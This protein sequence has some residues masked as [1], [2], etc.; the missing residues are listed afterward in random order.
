MPRIFLKPNLWQAVLPAVLAV[1]ALAV[2]APGCGVDDVDRT[3]PDKVRKCLFFE[4]GCEA[5]PSIIGRSP[6]EFYFNQTVIEVPAT[7]ELTFVGET[8]F[9]T[10]N[11]VFFEIQEDHLYVYRS[12]P[13]LEATDP[14]AINRG[15]DLTRTSGP[16]GAPIAVFPIE[17]H[18]DVIREYNAATGE[19]TNV[20]VEN[21]VDRPWY[22]RDFMRVDWTTNLVGDTN[23]PVSTVEGQVSYVVPQEDG[24]RDLG[25]ERTVLTPDYIDFVQY[26]ALEPDIIPGSEEFFGFPI[27]TCWLFTRLHQ[28]CQGG[29]I[30]IRN[31]FAKVPA[32][33][34][35]SV[36][37][38]DR[39]LADY[40]AFRTERYQYD[41]E[42]GVVEPSVV[43]LANRW[44]LWNDSSCYDADADLPY[45]G[46]SPDNLR[47][48]I[49]YLSEDHPEHLLDAAQAVGRAWDNA[50]KT[51]LLE[52]ADFTVEQLASKTVVRVCPHNPVL[53]GDPAECGEPGL[54]PQIGDIRYSFLYYV[55]EQQAAS[56]LG[57]GP[58]NVDP[59]TGEIISATAYFYGAPA[60]WLSQRTIDIFKVEEGL[61]EP[62]D[63]GLGT[64]VRQGV[65]TR[66]VVDG[67]EPGRP[68]V[69][70]DKIRQVIVDL[71]IEDKAARL[72]ELVQTGEAYID[73]LP[74]K[75]TRL[76][77]SPL[78]QLAVTEEMQQAIG[79]GIIRESGVDG[80]S[81][82]ESAATYLSDSFFG[83][84]E[85]Q[86][87]HLWHAPTGFHVHLASEYLE[88]RYAA[89]FEIIKER[90]YRDGV[91]DEEAALDFVEQQAF[92][93]IQLHEVGHNLGMMHNFA[94]SSDPL[95]FGPEY[96]QLRAMGG[97]VDGKRPAFEWQLLDEDGYMTAIAMGLRSLQSSS[98]MEYM[99]TTATDITLGM[100]DVAWVKNV[101]F[102]TVEV[103]DTDHPLVDV[104]PTRAELLQQGRLHY[105]FYPELISNAATY[106][107]RVQALYQRKSLNFRKVEMQRDLV[108]VPYNFCGDAYASG[109]EDCE[110]WDQGADAFERVQKHRLDYQNYYWFNAFKRERI[111]FGVDVFSYISRLYNRTYEPMLN[112]YKHWVNSEFIVRDGEAC[113]WYED[114]QRRE[115]PLPRWQAEPCGLTGFVAAAEA[116]NQFAEV[117]AT[118]DVG[119]YVRL[120]AGC[121]ETNVENVERGGIG[122]PTQ[123]TRINTNPAF[124]DNY[125]ARQP[126][127]APDAPFGADPVTT[128]KIERTS[129]YYH[130][131]DTTSCEL[132]GEGGFAFEIRDAVTQEVISETPYE[133]PL[134]VGKPA[135][136]VY[137]REQYGFNF[138]WKPVVMG[139]WWEKWMA[140]KAMGDPETNF[141]GVDAAS[142]TA[143]F[144]ISLNTFFGDEINQVVS[145]AVNEEAELYGAVIFQGRV[146]YPPVVDIFTSP[147]VEPS[148]DRD[149]TVD[150]D[151]EYTFRLQAMMN[152]A[153]QS[154]FVTDN[155]EYAET[156]RANRTFSLSDVE[157]PDDLKNDP[158]RFQSLRDPETGEIWWAVSA[159]RDVP[160]TDQPI[161]SAAYDLIWRIKERY[162]VD[163]SKGPGEQLKPGIPAW[164]P[165]SDIRFLNIMSATGHLFGSA[166]VG[167]GDVRL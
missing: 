18:F 20:I 5:G 114:G 6:T 116:V 152:A 105:T 155:F 37:Y 129:P 45:A 96:W 97:L 145:G 26:V 111:A 75:L 38:D 81:T 99:S 79:Q 165:R 42:Y 73:D 156:L 31:S 27:P 112:Q 78:D 102:D 51:A 47:P 143:S 154:S 53:E 67:F 4:G 62:V 95:N 115:S 80:F 72:R 107:E 162:Y 113:V 144:L 22:Q 146:E 71:S 132:N 7:S 119:C 9:M 163:G 103:F 130:L 49:F 14:N 167:S 100:Y 2:T 94:G 101:Y 166:F 1:T 120:Q 58:S 108:A 88:E 93:D 74:A 141:I 140:V 23:F 68:R 138:Y 83:L 87:R 60:R 39:R 52:A 56:P 92:I 133:I 159:N 34:Y 57:F 61:A 36:E 63:L 86:D 30:K 11:R 66:S 24:S 150:P 12:F 110:R 54:A 44:N 135:R 153:Y 15:D 35:Q 43:R 147:F 19:Q 122:N 106:E 131:A 59:L 109:A 40:G 134:G 64:L 125:A 126:G 127:A 46:C 123:I 118:P 128:L 149:P 76:R 32:S 89:L 3:Q 70:S 117:V 8:N 84:Q 139:S 10:T 148:R 142:D 55:P 104:T 124:C 48:I 50:F 33:T 151:Q 91:L 25:S 98:S 157:L 85:A 121:Y 90:Y 16:L 161:H 164:R 137:D 77:D 21:E 28:D 41:P 160:G 82:V 158:D 13:W 29:V 65:T 17:S 136:T 69:D